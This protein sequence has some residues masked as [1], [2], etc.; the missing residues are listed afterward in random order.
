MVVNANEETQ[1]V[2]IEHKG[3]VDKRQS[4]KRERIEEITSDQAPVVKK[5]LERREA[6]K[7][8][9][10][11][12][13]RKVV[14]PCEVPDLLKPDPPA[15]EPGA[16]QPSL[17]LVKPIKQVEKEKTVSYTVFYVKQFITEDAIGLEPLLKMGNISLENKAL[18]VAQSTEV[19]LF[20]A[21]CTRLLKKIFSLLSFLSA[22]YRSFH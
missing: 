20:L 17:I 19:N 3:V 21:C 6:E 14:D 18:F 4:L 2:T 7:G 11:E 22:T 8:S 16:P 1:K 15:T 10:I 5:E 13:E 12:I 9:V